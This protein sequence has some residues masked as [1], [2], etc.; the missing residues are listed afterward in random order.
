LLHGFSFT[1]VGVMPAAFKGLQTLGNVD[2]W[3]PLAMH[4][5]LVTGETARTFYTAL[6]IL[7]CSR[8]SADS[9]PA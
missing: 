6:A 1:V 9:H 3:V 8:S 7:W 5:Q 4:E 2:F